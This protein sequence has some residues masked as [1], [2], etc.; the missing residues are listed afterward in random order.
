MRED[1]GPVGMLEPCP[2]WC[3][4]EH[5]K[6]DPM[7]DRAHVSDGTESPAIER[8]VMA[9]DDA[10]IWERRALVFQIGLHRDVGGDRTWLYVGDGERRGVEIAVED[11]A[12]LVDIVAR[13][14]AAARA[15]AM[16]ADES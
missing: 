2:P 1:D 5:R 9:H 6:D 12:G 13:H 16:P 8:I 15:D 10:L 7:D 11:A 14:I 3:A 4:R